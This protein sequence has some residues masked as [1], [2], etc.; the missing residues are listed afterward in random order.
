MVLNG[1]EVAVHRWHMLSSFHTVSQFTCD[2]MSHGES[3]AHTR[4]SKF[5]VSGIIEPL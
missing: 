4:H 2:S 1:L 3:E 5:K